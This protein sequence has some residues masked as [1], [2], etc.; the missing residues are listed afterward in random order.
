MAF[1]SPA[2]LSIQDNKSQFYVHLILECR[3]EIYFDERLKRLVRLHGTDIILPDCVR[4][5]VS[6]MINMLYPN[7]QF[8]QQQRSTTIVDFWLPS[9]KDRWVGIS[10]ALGV[11]NKRNFMSMI[12]VHRQMESV[13]LGV[14][15]SQ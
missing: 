4:R 14:E 5:H 10:G 13:L 15:N 2:L 12:P 3:R 11:R 9:N 8:Y 6:T 7:S 1:A